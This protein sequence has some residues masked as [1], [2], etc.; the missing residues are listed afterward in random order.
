MT[1]DYVP[2]SGI[3]FLKTRDMEATTRFYR[4]TL[5]FALALDQGTCRIFRACPNCFFGFCLTDAGTGSEEVVL[6]L[7]IADV[8]GFARY[9]ESRAVPIEVQPRLNEKYQIYQ[10]FLRDP[11]GY[12]VEVQRFLDPAWEANRGKS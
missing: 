3:T 6:T 8:D 1:P 4:D 2:R 10:M 7:E 11:N 9:L 12:L 5:G